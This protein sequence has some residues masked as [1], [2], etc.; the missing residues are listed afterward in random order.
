MAK[1]PLLC[2]PYLPLRSSVTP[3]PLTPSPAAMLLH[4]LFC[5]AIGIPSPN[6][7]LPL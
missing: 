2:D 6:P 5:L 1:K 3:F 7:I 4:M